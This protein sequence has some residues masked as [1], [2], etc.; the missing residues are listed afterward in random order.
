MGGGSVAV[1][2][3]AIGAACAQLTVLA[4]GSM[5]IYD[6]SDTSDT[7]G[8]AHLGHLGH[9]GRGHTSVTTHPGHLGLALGQREGFQVRARPLPAPRVTCTRSH[10]HLYTCAQELQLGNRLQS[11]APRV[12]ARLVE[13]RRTPA[14]QVSR[15]SGVSNSVK[16][17]LGH[18]TPHERG[19]TTHLVKGATRHTPRRRLTPIMADV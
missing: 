10:G 11:G 16:T 15:V 8:A 9:T 18:D 12:G 14:A 4:L 2:G 5:V 13:P 17:H 7:S 6:T 3:A 1:P 19:H